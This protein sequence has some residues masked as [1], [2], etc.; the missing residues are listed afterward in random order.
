[1][2][3]S[4][5]I[6]SKYLSLYK[7]IFDQ[8][9]KNVIVKFR[10]PPDFSSEKIQIQ[11][12]DNQTIEVFIEGELPF[13]KG[14]LFQPVEKYE[15]SVLSNFFILTLTKKDPTEWKHIIKSVSKNDLSA[16]PKSCFLLGLEQKDHFPNEPLSPLLTLSVTYHFPAACLY[17]G[18]Y[19]LEQGNKVDALENYK[20]VA[21]E[22][23]DPTANL[24]TGIV[25]SQLH[26]TEESI[27]Y[28][29]RASD[30]GL[31]AATE[32]LN[33]IEKVEH[34]KNLN[35]EENEN[36]NTNPNIN[37]NIAIPTLI[38]TA[39]A[40][41]TAICGAALEATVLETIAAE[42]AAEVSE[43]KNSAEE[44]AAIKLAAAEAATIETAAVE[45]NIAE[46]IE[47]GKVTA[48]TAAASLA[49]ESSVERN[50]ALE[51]GAAET[52]A[53]ETAI[54]GTATAEAVAIEG[55]ATEA[56]IEQIQNN[57]NTNNDSKTDKMLITISCLAIG[58]SL[59][60]LFF[61]MRRKK[62]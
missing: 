21:D 48:E 57:Q 10:M 13:L 18:N 19:Y 14:T 43:I 25:L 23:N 11:L 29:H 61:T 17:L 62:H 6:N 37:S 42:T 50:A 24:Q 12:H 32:V 47:V 2:S 3:E 41:T 26:R 31:V 35:E 16:D 36:L 34:Q 46:T 4:Q 1:M 51:V 27:E 38:A 15:K 45:K 55:A 54:V 60:V 56:T 7:W 49:I 52:A 5:R 30:L 59:A 8:N 44:S 28:L 22:Y 40:E 58:V 20:I 9:D 33:S 39:A 53:I